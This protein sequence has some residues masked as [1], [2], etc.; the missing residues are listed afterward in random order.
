MQTLLVGGKPR[1]D[2]SYHSFVQQMCAYYRRQPKLLPDILAETI[3]LQ[4]DLHRILARGLFDLKRVEQA[5]D[6]QNVQLKYG[7]RVP[8]ARWQKQFSPILQETV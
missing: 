5:F 4:P 3:K 1:T 8:C 6:N 2:K 7:G